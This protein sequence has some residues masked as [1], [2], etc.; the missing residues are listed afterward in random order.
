MW[1]IY[2]KT[3]GN[4]FSLFKA[5]MKLTPRHVIKS[6]ILSVIDTRFGQLYRRMLN[7]SFIKKG[8]IKFPLN[9]WTVILQYISGG[10][11]AFSPKRSTIQE[12]YLLQRGPKRFDSEF[13]IL[14]LSRSFVSSRLLFVRRRLLLFWRHL[15]TF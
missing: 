8:V 15:L 1:R 12:K 7:N 3:F 13:Y 4:F 10:S 5:K 14:F 9:I 11:E 2:Y 6:K